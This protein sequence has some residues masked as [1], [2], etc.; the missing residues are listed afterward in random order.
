MG[1][2]LKKVGVVTILTMV[3][4]L[5][6]KHGNLSDVTPSKI[7]GFLYQY[8]HMAPIIYIL[9]FTFVPLTLFPDSV[10]AIASGLVFGFIKGSIYTM[11]GAV[12]GGTLAFF[13]ARYLG[14]GFVDSKLGGKNGEIRKG[15]SE[16]GFWLVLMLRLIPLLPFDVISYLSGIS[17]IKYKDFLVGTVIGIIPGVMV[18]VNIGHHLVDMNSKGLYIS[19]G[20]LVLLVVASKLLKDKVDRWGKGSSE[21]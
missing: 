5:L 8:G 14:K 15:I 17:D 20:C 6:I 2:V 1:N 12:C 10:L 3:I 18:F 4:C 19:I 13:L 7:R 16:K 9:L 11:I 21:I